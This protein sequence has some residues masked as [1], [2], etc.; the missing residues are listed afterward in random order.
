MAPQLTHSR[1]SKKLFSNDEIK[2]Y[3]ITKFA[4]RCS[5]KVSEQQKEKV[6]ERKKL[7]LLDIITMRKRGIFGDLYQNEE[8]KKYQLVHFNGTM[9]QF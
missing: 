4:D 8:G 3:N 6:S 2:L 5:R 1:P 7:Q 9:S